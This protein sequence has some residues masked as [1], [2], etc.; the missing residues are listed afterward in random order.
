MNLTDGFRAVKWISLHICL[1]IIF[2]GV[3][4]AFTRTSIKL[5]VFLMSFDIDKANKNPENAIDKLEAR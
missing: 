5:N 3:L 4:L 2:D 1:Q